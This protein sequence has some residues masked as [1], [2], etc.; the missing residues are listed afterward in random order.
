M[1]LN[2]DGKLIC[3]QTFGYGL[4]EEAGARDQI[5]RIVWVADRIIGL[6]RSFKVCDVAIEGYA[7]GAKY[8]GEKIAELVGVVK[9][10]LFLSCQ[11]VPVAVPPTTARSKV[12]GKGCGKID[13]K[14]VRPLLK[15]RGVVIS[16]PD[17]ADAYVV[18][19]Y[20]RWRMLTDGKRDKQM[21]GRW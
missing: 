6:V 10:Q 1:V 16:D 12:F 14:F 19:R 13:K 8:G 9:T 17:Q 18:A 7:Y 15:Q 5:E 11:I 4:E 2:Q 3:N 20:L 21:G